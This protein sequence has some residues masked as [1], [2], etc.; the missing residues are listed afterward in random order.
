MWNHL[1]PSGNDRVSGGSF[2]PL[3]FR[4]SLAAL[5]PSVLGDLW[6]VMEGGSCG[7]WGGGG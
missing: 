6:A 5:V 4:V 1:S 3:V 7:V 2:L